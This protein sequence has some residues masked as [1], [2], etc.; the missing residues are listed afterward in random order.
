MKQ[1]RHREKA[2]TLPYPM[3]LNPL[4]PIHSTSLYPSP[5]LTV[6]YH[7]ALLYHPP[8]F[9]ANITDTTRLPAPSLHCTHTHVFFHCGG[10]CAVTPT[11]SIH[12][13]ILTSPHKNQ[14]PALHMASDTQNPLLPHSFPPAVRQMPCTATASVRKTDTWWTNWKAKE[15]CHHR[16]LLVTENVICLLDKTPKNS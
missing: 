12:G 2:S 9:P 14:T 8:C 6:I 5:Y 10:I 1:R 11:L 15:K 4:C 3:R 13:A 7:H 16:L